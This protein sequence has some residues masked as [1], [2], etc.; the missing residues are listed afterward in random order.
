MIRLESVLK[1]FGFLASS[2]RL[3]NVFKTSWQDALNTSWR[4]LENI[5][6]TSWKRLEGVL[7]MS[8]QDVLNTPWRSLESILKTSWKRL[9]DVLKTFLQEVLKTSWKRLEDVLKTYSQDEYIGLDQDVFWR[10]KAKANIFVL[11]KTSSEDKDERRL[12]DVFIKT[13]VCWVGSLKVP[14]FHLF[15]IIFFL[16]LAC[17]YYH[18]LCFAKAV[19]VFHFVFHFHFSAFP[20]SFSYLLWSSCYWLTL[21]FLSPRIYNQLFLTHHLLWLLLQNTLCVQILSLV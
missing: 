9:E 15:W 18:I 7:K 16:F 2:G 11:I 10:R 19:S 17:L 12:Q 3:Q 13:N 14:C 5:L 6:K 1:P 21:L 4:R 8:W 20:D